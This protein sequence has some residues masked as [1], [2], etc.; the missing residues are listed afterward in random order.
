LWARTWLDTC[1]ASGPACATSRALRAHR[2]IVPSGARALVWD[3]Q[4]STFAVGGLRQDSGQ[5]QPFTGAPGSV[6]FGPLLS[7]LLG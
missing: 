6:A 1:A 5:G 7:L 2:L 4:H 3:K